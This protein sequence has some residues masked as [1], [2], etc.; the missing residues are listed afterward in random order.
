M[1]PYKHQWQEI[2]ERAGCDPRSYSGRGMC[3]KTCVAVEAE[4]LSVVFAKVIEALAWYT[5]SLPTEDALDMHAVA[6]EALVDM[7]TDA[8]RSTLTR[9]HWSRTTWSWPAKPT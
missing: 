4:D 1:K 3:G 8:S 6:V 5:K 9:S 7:E 2:L